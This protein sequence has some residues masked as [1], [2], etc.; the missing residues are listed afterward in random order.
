[1]LSR[2]IM[3]LL[4][5]YVLVVLICVP[6]L[7]Q[8][9]CKTTGRP[10]PTTMPDGGP[11]VQSHDHTGMAWIAGGTFTMGTDAADAEPQE[12]PARRVHVNGF[13]IDRTDVTNAQFRKFV[14][15]AHYLTTAEQKVDWNELSKQLPPGT[16]KPSDEMLEPGSLVFVSPRHPVDLDDVTAWWKWTPGASWRH[17]DGPGSSIVGKDDY[18]VTQVSWFDAVAYAKWAGKK[19]PT[20]SQ[21]E[22]AARGGLEQKRYAWGD[23]DPISPTPRCNIWQGHF[24]DR[25]DAFDGYA[26]TSPVRAFAPNGYGLNDMA[27]NVWQWCADWYSPTER[28]TRGGSFLCSAEYCSGYRVSAR[29]GTTPDTSLNNT[30][31]RCV[32]DP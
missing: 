26:G 6:A 1:M 17:P 18:P 28:V 24:P 7:G 3:S 5:S 11:V 21:W 32:E 25:N 19:L 15:V 23:E 10:G 13:W 22:F 4:K 8:D 30:G 2:Q 14:E 16:P 31:F 20:E 9:C 12:R 29:H 27:G